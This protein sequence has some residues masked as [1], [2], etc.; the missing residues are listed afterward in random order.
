MVCPS[1]L[2]SKRPPKGQVWE[3]VQ[4]DG[5]RRMHQTAWVVHEL[6]QVLTVKSLPPCSG[7]QRQEG[8]IPRDLGKSVSL[9]RTLYPVSILKT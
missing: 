5:T 7:Q 8:V 3:V 1:R 4:S 9:H 6:S 2:S